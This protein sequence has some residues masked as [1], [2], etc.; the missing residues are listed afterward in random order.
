MTLLWTSEKNNH[1]TEVEQTK[2]KHSFFQG[3]LG[4]ASDEGSQSGWLTH[5]DHSLPSSLAAGGSFSLALTDTKLQ[6]C[7]FAPVF[8]SKA[9]VRALAVLSKMP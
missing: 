8:F 5:M 3:D 4:A 7:P 6:D 9:L 1:S 2:Y